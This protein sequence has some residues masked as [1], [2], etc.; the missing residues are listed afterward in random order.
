VSTKEIS[1]RHD[2]TGQGVRRTYIG[3]TRAKNIGAL[4]FVDV[5]KRDMFN[6]NCADKNAALISIFRSRGE[7]RDE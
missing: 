3:E 7:T 6:L 2:D 5:S 1:P 4:S